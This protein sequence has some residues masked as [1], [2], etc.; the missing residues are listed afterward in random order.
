MLGATALLELS[1]AG[2]PGVE[3]R[4]ESLD[5]VLR[6]PVPAMFFAGLSLVLGWAFLLTGASDCRRRMFLPVAFLFLNQ[7]ILFAPAE[8]ALAPL[9]GLGGILLIGAVTWLHFFNRR[10][11]YWRNRL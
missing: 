7:W 5:K 9:I 11:T 3:F 2:L 1:N 4:S 10:W 6:V 8:G